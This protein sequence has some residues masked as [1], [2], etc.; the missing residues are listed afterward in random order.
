MHMHM[1]CFGATG[2]ASE[3]ASERAAEQMSVRAER[4][5]FCL[6]CEVRELVSAYFVIA[7]AAAWKPWRRRRRAE[8][9]R[10]F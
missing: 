3:G 2:R 8:E 6:V 5:H 4:T 9:E 1:P 7:A 10:F